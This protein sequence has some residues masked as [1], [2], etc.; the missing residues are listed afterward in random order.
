MIESGNNLV[1]SENARGGGLDSAGTPLGTGV[2]GLMAPGVGIAQG[3]SGPASR[4]FSLPLLLRH[5]WLMFT[6]FA[7][8]SGLGVPLVWMFVAPVYT[9]KAVVRVSPVVS[10]IVFKTEDNGIVPLYRSY[11]NT[12]VS[13][14][15]SPQV[16]MRVLDREEIQRTEWYTEEARSP[17][18]GLRTPRSPLERLRE[19]LLIRPRRDTELIDVSITVLDRKEAKLIIDAVIDEYKQLSDETLRESDVL[20]FE[21]LSAEQASLQREIN[22]LVA[23][24]YNLSKRLGTTGPEELRSQFSTHLDELE[25]Q[26]TELQ[27]ELQMMKWDWEHS[28]ATDQGGDAGDDNKAEGEGSKALEVRYAQDRQWHELHLRF[29]TAKHELTLGW[30]RF[31]ESH[32][33]IQQ[34][35]ADVEHAKHLL[36]Q[37]ETQVDAWGPAPIQVTAADAPVIA[38]MSREMLEQKIQRREHELGL[39]EQEIERQRDK[40]GRAGDTAEDIAHYDEELRYKR[41]MYDAVRSRLEHLGLES[42]A[43]ARI[44]VAAWAIEPSLPSRDRRILLTAM[45]LVAAVMAGAGAGYLRI[46]T[47]PRIREA[48]DVQRSVH[49]PF[50]GQLPPLPRAEEVMAD[51]SP[52]VLEGIRMVR[53]ALLER[54]EGTG[55][56]V[57]HITS[58]TSRTGKTS[59]ALL[60][61]R[62]LAMLGKRTL[63][64]EADLRRPVLRERLGLQA[65]VGLETLLDGGADDDDVIFKTGVPN[66]EVL[67]AMEP[68]SCFNPELL[69][70]GVLS[71]CLERWKKTYDF[72][73]LDS[74]PVL[75]VADARILSGQADGTIMVLRAAHCRR[76]AM[77]QAYADLGSSGGSLLGTILIGTRVG[78]G[79]GYGYYNDYQAYMEAPAKLHAC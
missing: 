52:F 14:I 61:S 20:R 12:Q 26:Y 27:R 21:T 54:L 10:R 78:Q 6:V 69:A 79:Y 23:A 25:S 51:R 43:P 22:G 39:L 77:F 71:A 60:L 42:K 17:L 8:I 34:L 16:L 65:H 13:V 28:H 29:E 56:Q 19:D 5:K 48:G 31:G 73:I 15:Q 50:L 4:G 38:Q 9:A 49:T 66:F 45:T 7:L 41:E 57:V 24:K 18:A 64:V 30:Q 1:L 46:M 3:S 58:S 59:V 40:V 33:R 68:T 32:P 70:N 72:I 2:V 76:N 11:L 62:S 36:Q 47:D 37:R 63:L 75:P 35:E 53:T 44:S 74:P 55:K 67:P